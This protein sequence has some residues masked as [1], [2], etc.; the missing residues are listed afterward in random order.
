M[1]RDVTLMF[2]EYLETMKSNF[3]DSINAQQKMLE[4]IEVFA[5]AKI[6]AKGISEKVEVWSMDKVKLY[7]FVPKV[8]KTNSIPTLISYAL[9][10]KYYMMDLQE[11]KSFIGGLLEQG[12]DL[13]VL[14]WGYPTKDDLYLTLEDYILGYID[15]AVDYIREETGNDKINL[16]GVCQGGTFSVIYNALRPEKV[17][18]LI[19]MVVPIDFSTDDKLLFK[20]G[21]YLN[22][23]TMVDAYGVLPGDFMNNGFLMLQPISL[24]TNKYLDLID[25][26]DDQDKINNFLTMEKWIFDSPGQAGEAIRQFI[27]DLYKENKLIKGTLKIGE[28]IVDMKKIENPLLNI[29][30]KKDHQVPNNS[31]EPLPKYVASKD[32]HNE[33]VDTGHIGLFVSGKS[34][35]ITIPLIS[36]WLKE[37]DQ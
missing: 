22:I 19:T 32:T 28:E 14:D 34:L 25:D 8:K 24:T 13:Y 7:H 31:S 10:N 1:K 18:N 11:G 37:R 9:V 35:K 16:L 4:G 2:N 30:A 20:W 21:K 23:D 5:N 29:Y 27:N 6:P 26:V 3:E 33:L 15:G 17:K 12:I 36:N